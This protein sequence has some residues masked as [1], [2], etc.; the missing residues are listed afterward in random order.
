MM[1]LTD[2]FY[3]DLAL[4]FL[5][6]RDDGDGGLLVDADGEAFVY[7][8]GAGF[9][10]FVVLG[11]VAGCFCDFSS[12]VGLAAHAP[13]IGLLFASVWIVIV[14]AGFLRY[15]IPYRVSLMMRDGLIEGKG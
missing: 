13:L 3:S 2:E 1:K 10:V 9:L 12:G 4:C 6:V 14:S 5:V 8:G 15:R 7:L 11:F